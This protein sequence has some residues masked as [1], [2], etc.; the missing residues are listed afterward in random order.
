MKT[1]LLVDS[2]HWAYH[3][4]SLS[5]KK[6]NQHQGLSFHIEPI[7]GNEK[8]IKKI[9]KKY[10]RFFVLGWQTYDRISFLPKKETLT[11]IHSYHSWDNKKT[12]PDNKLK[13]RP[14]QELVDFLNDFLRVNAVSQQLTTVFAKAGLNKVYYTPNGVDTDIFKPCVRTD[15]SDDFAVGYSGSKAHDWRKGV[16]EFIKPAVKKAGAKLKIAMLS[17]D[18]YVELKNMPVFYHGLD[19]YICA[20]SSEGF[21]LSVLEAAACGV[22]IISTRVSGC[23]DLIEDSVNGFLVDRGVEAIVKKIQL[24]KNDEDLRLQIAHRM[25]DDIKRIWC[26][27]R[28]TKDWT[29]FIKDE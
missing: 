17:T 10:D 13:I 8:R 2:L 16:S 28:R 25:A 7:K 3:A 20:S 11:G 23:V 4:I 5:I 12:S 18:N 29:D 22:S 9:Y 15:K 6:Y 24:L 27:A 26:W 19:A 21:S 14:P 1:L